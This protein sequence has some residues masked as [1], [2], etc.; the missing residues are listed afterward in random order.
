M[1]DHVII[2]PSTNDNRKTLVE[3]YLDNK[4]D[5]LTRRPTLTGIRRNIECRAKAVGLSRAELDFISGIDQHN[6]MQSFY[7]CFN[8]ADMHMKLI[9]YQSQLLDADPK[10]LEVKPFEEYFGSKRALTSAGVKAVF[11]SHKQCL[12]DYSQLTH[13]EFHNRYTS[14]L[15]E[16]FH[17]VTLMRPVSKDVVKRNSFANDFS[18][19]VIVVRISVNPIGRFGFI[20]SLFLL[21]F[22]PCQFYLK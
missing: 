12:R 11:A 4:F 14:Y 6:S 2:S 21:L 17:L 10:V 3:T 9:K 22:R 20:R 13:Q 5:V 18:S 15:L 19:V 7:V 8:Q 1:V 16:L